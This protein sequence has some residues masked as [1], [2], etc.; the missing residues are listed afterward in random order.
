MFQD[1]GDFQNFPPQRNV[2][3]VYIVKVIFCTCELLETHSYF[4]HN[5]DFKN[6]FRW[7][8]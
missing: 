7:K 4:G 3:I 2:S 5:N 1:Y 6:I 8:I